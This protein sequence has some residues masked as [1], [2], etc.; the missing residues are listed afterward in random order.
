MLYFLDRADAGRALA[1][2]LTA[3]KNKPD[4]IVLALPRGGVPVGYEIATALHL[5]LD[6]ILVRKL[7]MP[8]HEELAMGAI[9]D[10]NVQVLNEDIV[11]G[12]NIQPLTIAEVAAEERI[13]LKRRQKA[14]RQDK[15][16][17]VIEGRTVILVD[18]GCATGAN[19]KAA[20]QAVTKQH[21]ARIVVALPVVSDS[22]YEMLREIADEV[23]CVDIPDPFYGVGA[24]YRKFTQ[25]TD[26]EVKAL[27]AGNNHYP[28]KRKTYPS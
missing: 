12:F 5:P 28:E 20:V 8:G 9:A 3:Y 1:N 19:M 21:P 22:A 23:I 24:F 17:P 10:G 7:G 13:E 26:A 6:V 15:P 16:P 4:A 25:T 2:E 11:Q 18:D 27:L 14:Y